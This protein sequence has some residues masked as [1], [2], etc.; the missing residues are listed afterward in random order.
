MS[1]NDKE[2]GQ[3]L[4]LAAV[5][6]VAIV[7]GA[8]WGLWGADVV[9]LVLLVALVALVALLVLFLAPN[10]LKNLL[11]PK[12]SECKILVAERK[13]WVVLALRASQFREY[14]SHLS[15]GQKITEKNACELLYKNSKYIWRGTQKEFE[16]LKE[17]VEK[18]PAENLN[19]A[20]YLV[21]LEADE[22]LPGLARDTS[23]LE[24]RDAFLA[25]A[26]KAKIVW[27]SPPLHLNSLANKGFYL[28]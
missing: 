14:F 6:I 17:E 20:F 12:P 24:R 7:G 13:S 23:P 2:Q 18:F 27:I 15:P 4:R 3:L 8:I 21:A 1:E 25:L 5:V 22:E 9:A 19:D 26:G 16:A 28:V 10:L 11:E